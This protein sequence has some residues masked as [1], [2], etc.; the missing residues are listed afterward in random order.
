MPVKYS[1]YS[2]VSE[3]SRQQPW[4]S[5]KCLLI[6]LYLQKLRSKIIRKIALSPLL[7][8][9]Y[10]VC[11]LHN[12]K[13]QWTTALEPADTHIEV[14]IPIIPLRKWKSP[15]SNTYMKVQTRFSD[16]KTILQKQEFASEKK[17]RIKMRIQTQEMVLYETQWLV[18]TLVFI[19]CF[20]KQ[21]I[22]KGTN[23]YSDLPP[24]SV[25]VETFLR[26]FLSNKFL[27]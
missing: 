14:F 26:K 17:K 24:R 10:A 20:I 8:Q 27:F 18:D 6:P 11:S 15:W 5:T 2:N 13:H 16:L 22:R 21:F 12:I 19:L 7:S 23:T 25:R 3:P 1:C 9:N 4:L